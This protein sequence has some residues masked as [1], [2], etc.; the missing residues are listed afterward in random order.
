MSYNIPK[1]LRDKRKLKIVKDYLKLVEK[2]GWKPKKAVY[3]I[4]V[5]YSICRKTLYNYMKKFED[6]PVHML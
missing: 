3:K 4:C 5:K 6:V 2:N 1:Y